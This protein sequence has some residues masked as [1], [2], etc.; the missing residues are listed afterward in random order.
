MHERKPQRELLESRIGV[1][2]IR[3]Y[4]PREISGELIV[5]VCLGTG[6]VDIAWKLVEK[7]DQRYRFL[8]AKLL[9][10]PCLSSGCSDQVTEPSTY[11]LVGL[12]GL[13]HPEPDALACLG[14]S[15]GLFSEP[16]L[17]DLAEIRFVHPMNSS[18]LM[19]VGRSSAPPPARPLPS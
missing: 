17:V 4:C 1:P 6:A 7:N 13:F 19:R 11:D 3:N 9:R 10:D 18:R 2:S 15:A 5:G 8:M 14:L 12:V 16:E